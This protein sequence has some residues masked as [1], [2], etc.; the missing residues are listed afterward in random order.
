[1]PWTARW[2]QLWSIPGGTCRPIV[3]ME[4][5]RTRLDRVA[6]LGA[7]PAGSPQEAEQRLYE[8][9]LDSAWRDAEDLGN[10][11]IGQRLRGQAEPRLDRLEQAVALLEDRD[12]DVAGRASR[13]LS[14][15]RR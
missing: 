15:D 4:L 1:M 13:L 3:R 14:L 7:G 5:D 12:S 6:V 11:T 10:L 9:A 2:P 8:R